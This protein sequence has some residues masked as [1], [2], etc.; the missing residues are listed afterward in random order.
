EKIINEEFIDCDFNRVD[1]YLYLS[2]HTHKE[3]L[4]KEY[5]ASL[6]SGFHDLDLLPSPGYFPSLGPAIRYGRQAQLHPQK[7]LLGLIAAIRGMGGVIHGY[8]RVVDFEDGDHPF[9]KTSE[10]GI[11]RAKHIVVTTNVPVND[12]VKIHTKQA[13][14]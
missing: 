5:E 6:Q 10:E 13:P 3:F 7:Y 14:Y 8:S 9:V 1:G 11:L 4:Q 12:R 2:E